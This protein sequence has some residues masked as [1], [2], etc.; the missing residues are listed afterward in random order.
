MPGGLTLGFAMHLVVLSLPKI[1]ETLSSCPLVNAPRVATTRQLSVL[2]PSP[3][4]HHCRVPNVVVVCL[5]S[6]RRNTSLPP[7]Y[8]PAAPEINGRCQ[9]G[10]APL[11][12]SRPVPVS[13]AGLD[14]IIDACG[15]VCDV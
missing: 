14:G 8:S 11:R 13:S 2:L 5:A 4:L 9:D 3:A 12:P 10:P 6:D 15:V 1:G 7:N